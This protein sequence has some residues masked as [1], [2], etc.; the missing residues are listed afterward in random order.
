[1]ETQE[2][3]VTLDDLV[4]EKIVTM[5]TPVVAVRGKKFS[6][7]VARI[8]DLSGFSRR[9]VYEAVCRLVANGRLS[10]TDTREFKDEYGSRPEPK[11]STYKI[12]EYRV[13]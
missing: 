1:M 4:Y 8:V 9:E 2:A 5:G 12:A 13:V 10:R 7:N 6:K 3:D 11:R